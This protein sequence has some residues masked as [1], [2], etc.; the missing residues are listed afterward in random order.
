MWEPPPD[1]NNH[2]LFYEKILLP[3][4]PLEYIKASLVL[5]GAA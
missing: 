4:V 5:R 1:N 2:R 3:K